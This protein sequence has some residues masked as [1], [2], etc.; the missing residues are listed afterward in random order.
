MSNAWS[1]VVHR[2]A[3]TS[4]RDAHGRDAA[5]TDDAV[6]SPSTYH[7]SARPV[8][9]RVLHLIHHLD[10]GQCET[11]ADASHSSVSKLGH[12]QRLDLGCCEYVTDAG[13]MTLSALSQLQRLVT[14][15]HGKRT[16]K[17]STSCIFSLSQLRYLTFIEH[18]GSIPMSYDLVVAHIKSASLELLQ[19]LDISWCKITVASLSSIFALSQLRHLN[20]SGCKGITDDGI[21]NISVLSELS[22][23]TWT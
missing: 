8:R 6:L 12:L 19:H 16:K 21:T 23:N 17:S 22:S 18:P 4:P 13:I 14:H 10:L 7:L 3:F 2:E 5:A 9:R 1:P 11:I 15:M 20:L